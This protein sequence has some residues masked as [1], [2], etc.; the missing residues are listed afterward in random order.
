MPCFGVQIIAAYSKELMIKIINQQLDIAKSCK[1]VSELS[2]QNIYVSKWYSNKFN[3]PSSFFCS[4]GNSLS[5]DLI[6]YKLE[7]YIHNK[8]QQSAIGPFVHGSGIVLCTI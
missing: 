7:I 6:L 1:F 3:F 4:I 5:F 8:R 2:V